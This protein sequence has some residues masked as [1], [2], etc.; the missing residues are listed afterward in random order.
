MCKIDK[1]QNAAT[2]ILNLGL[3]MTNTLGGMN[4]TVNIGNLLNVTS[5]GGPPQQTMP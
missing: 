4:S 1:T 2:G 3:G 5:I